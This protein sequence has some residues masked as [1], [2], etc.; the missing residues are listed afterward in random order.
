MVDY[1]VEG[2][3]AP[4]VLT[5]RIAD[6]GPGMADLEAVLAGRYRSETGLGLGIAGTRRLADVFDIKSGP[7]GTT[8]TIKKLFPR[9]SPLVT[10][11]Q[12]DLIA[13]QIVD[14]PP[15][16]P[17]EEVQRQNRE[18]LQTLEQLQ[19]RQRELERVNRE[20]ED[21]NRGVVAL[22]AELDERA[23]HL[24]RADELKTRFLSNMT[25]EFRTP[26]N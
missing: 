20:L 3:L 26:V 18:L 16:G 6:E 2:T 1:F 24:R 25:H 22:Y 19:E 5:V 4:Q 8:V 10:A 23:D 21:T 13:R 12:F 9:R 14:V 7:S 11:A 15:S 17:A